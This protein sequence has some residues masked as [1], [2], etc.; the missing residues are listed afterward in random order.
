V[1]NN[2]PTIYLATPIEGI[3]PKTWKCKKKKVMHTL[4]EYIPGIH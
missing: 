3:W 2:R 4:V 1:Q